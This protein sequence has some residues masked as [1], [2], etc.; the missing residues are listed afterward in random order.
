MILKTMQNEINKIKLVNKQPIR[1]FFL[2]E[3]N[4]FNIYISN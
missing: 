1:I 3:A 2:L 4:I